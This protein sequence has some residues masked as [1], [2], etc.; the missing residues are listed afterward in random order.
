MMVHLIT[1]EDM[2]TAI[3]YSE[4]YYHTQGIMIA[5]YDVNDN[6][7]YKTNQEV[8]LELQKLDL[9][10]GDTLIGRIIYDDESSI[11]GNEI[12]NGLIIL[13]AISLVLFLIILQVL[14]YY[15]NSWYKLLENDFKQIGNEDRD[16]H[17]S[18][19]DLVN[20]RM[21]KLIASEKKIREYQK[22]YTKFLAHDI[23]TPLTVIRAYVEG[24]SLGRLEANE[25]INQE[26]IEEIKEMEK[27]I[28]K[29]IE[30][31]ESSIPKKQNVKPLAMEIIKRLEE[32]F[33][34]KHI[35][36]EYDLDD[37]ELEIAKLD[38]SRLFENILFNAFYYTKDSGKIR[39]RISKT[40][41]TLV[42]TDNG[43]GMDQTTIEKIM[44]GPYRANDA[45]I[46]HDKGS[47]MGLQ[48]VK[49]IV[50]RYGFK[51]DIESE[52]GSGTKMRI[53]FACEAGE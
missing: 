46:L 10:D 8:S 7:I 47:G 15:V 31:N 48:I 27:L 18:D 11:L 24:I 50:D 14:F 52:V 12:S 25:Q 33:K 36:L 45:I 2:D 42:I 13:N 21:T 37:C 35:S 19:L 43:I 41:Q 1:R 20:Q 44:E 26:I 29:F 6:L 23:K 9:M 4:H 32:V 17:F 34:L 5:L 39:V 53:D 3:T 16:F 28:P 40:N 22:E 51:L 30:P 38:F 49:E